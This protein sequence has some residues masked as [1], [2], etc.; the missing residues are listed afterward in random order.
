ML[1]IPVLALDFDGLIVDGLPESVLVCWNGYHGLGIESFSDQGLAAVPQAFIE[2]FRYYRNFAKHV[3]HFLMPFQRSE[4]FA[5]QAAF[6]DSYAALDSQEVDLFIGKV[7]Q[8]REQSRRSHRARW[9]SYHEFYPGLV[10]M[11]RSPQMPIRIVTAKDKGSVLELLQYAGVQLSNV[12]IY[13]SCREKLTALRAI[14][15]EFGIARQEVR[16]FDDNVLNARDAQ[17]AGYHAHWAVWG[18]HAPEH[19][20]IA[21]EAGLRAV[22]LSELLDLAPRFSSLVERG[23]D[24]I[25]TR[26]G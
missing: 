12:R 22:E 8:Y 2:R 25:Q 14:A 19:F 17:R 3:G 24:A 21:A 16:F 9:L 15:D 7:L 4:T 11:L 5:T 6:D 13:G 10:D 1:T 20:E 23:S 26:W 18:Y